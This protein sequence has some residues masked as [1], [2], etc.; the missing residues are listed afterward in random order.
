MS[1]WLS[2]VGG[3]RDNKSNARDAIIGLREQLHLITKKEEYLQ[4][5]VDDELRKAREQVTTN[6]RAA[7][8]ALRQKKMYE[9][10]LD[11]LAGSRMTLETQV[12]AIENANMNLETMRAMQRGSAALKQIH[13]S[14]DID[15]VDNTM[16][17]IREQMSLSNEISEAISNPVGVGTELDED[18]LRAEL[19]E[20]EQ[21]ELHSRLVGADAAPAHRIASP[22]PLPSSTAAVPS[23]PVETDEEAELRALQ[24]ELAM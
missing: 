24:A 10:E 19:Q 16:D 21:D 9:T 22:A 18:E 15:K 6:K 2:W 1:S 11:R 14:M 13:A 7:Q 20:L 8:A 3:K 4:T 17:S 23:R 12:N 5:K